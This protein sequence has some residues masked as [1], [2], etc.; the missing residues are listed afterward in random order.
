MNVF[1]WAGWEVIIDD[2][3]YTFKVNPSCKQGCTNKNP[4]F[5]CSEAVDCVISLLKE[6]RLNALVPVYTANSQGMMFAVQLTFYLLLCSFCMNDVHINTFIYEL[7]EKLFSPFNGL[8]KNKDR[9]I[10][11]LGERRKLSTY[12]LSERIQSI[13]HNMSL[14]HKQP[15]QFSALSWQVLCQSDI[16]HKKS[17][18]RD[19]QLKH[20][21]K[22]LSAGKTVVHLLNEWLMGQRTEWCH[23]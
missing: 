1:H 17:G 2:Q 23:L 6:D 22:D 13:P 14:V 5:S 4:D 15:I 10:E 11:T 21:H 18:K 8:N 3:V 7:M 19:S 16:K 20:L 12:S 9:W